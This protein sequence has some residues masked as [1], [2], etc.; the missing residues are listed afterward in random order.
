MKSS[1][2]FDVCHSRYRSL[3]IDTCQ[4]VR[5]EI[6][7]LIRGPSENLC[8]LTAAE[9]NFRPKAAGPMPRL[10]LPATI[11]KLPNQRDTPCD[12]RKQQILEQGR[13]PDVAFVRGIRFR[14]LGGD[15][16]RCVFQEIDSALLAAAALR[17]AVTT[18]RTFERKRGVATRT[19]L[20]G[21]GCFSAALLAF[22]GSIL[23]E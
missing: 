20:S 18:G 1:E 6:A 15:Q 14:F 5:K 8:E 23:A 7:S 2:I 21:I 22:H 13:A 16:D 12:W 4:S 10:S 11:E 3:L 17:L 19:E 9:T